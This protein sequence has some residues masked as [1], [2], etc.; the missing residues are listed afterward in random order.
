MAVGRRTKG[1]VS[2]MERGEAIPE[3]AV[4]GR[5][6]RRG[7]AKVSVFYL[8]GMFWRLFGNQLRLIRWGV[9]CVG[10]LGFREELL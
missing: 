1:V 6:C 8:R 3:Y 2:F 5:V 7:N 9:L 10:E 4:S